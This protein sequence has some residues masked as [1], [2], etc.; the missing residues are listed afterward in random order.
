MPELKLLSFS[1]LTQRSERYGTMLFVLYVKVISIVAYHRTY[2]TFVGAP[3]MEE[4]A[5]GLASAGCVH[6]LVCIYAIV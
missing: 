5:S 4:Y 1:A 2:Q 6:I 3:L